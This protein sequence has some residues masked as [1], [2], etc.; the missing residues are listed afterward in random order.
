VQDEWSA[1]IQLQNE[2]A[3]KEIQAKKAKEA[4]KKRAYLSELQNNIDHKRN[5]RA[6]VQVQKQK[7]A[8][9]RMIEEQKLRQ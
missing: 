6:Q 5:E 1:L 8:A 9:E 4:L 7:E 2:V 3:E